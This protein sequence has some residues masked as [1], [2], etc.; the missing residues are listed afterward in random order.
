MENRNKSVIK[1]FYKIRDVPYRIPLSLEEPDDC[2]SGKSSRLFKI[3]TEVGYDVRYRVCTFLWSDMN[4]S[5]ELRII[6]HEDECTHS[7][8]EVKIENEWK[9]VDATW[10]KSLQGLFTINNWDGKSD[11]IV[12]VP[13]RK[14]F[15]TEES[16][17]IMQ[18]SLTEQTIIDDLK[19][20][21]KF[22]KAFNKWLEGH[23][24]R[25]KDFLLVQ[26]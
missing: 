18:E 24:K 12:A 23:R 6:P 10:D 21:G 19:K 11:T 15:S 14:C 3:F 2:C 13:V 1:E 5:R 9:I 25:G 22:Y 8:L 20:N 16:T 17:K 7:Y 26:K 4:L